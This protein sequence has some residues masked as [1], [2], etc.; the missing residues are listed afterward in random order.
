MTIEDYIKKTI[1]SLIKGVDQEVSDGTWINV[2]FDI[3]VGNTGNGGKVY[4]SD[5]SLSRVKFA[6]R[7]KRV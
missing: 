7:V 4:V 3:G 6:L 2:E 1:A 5:D